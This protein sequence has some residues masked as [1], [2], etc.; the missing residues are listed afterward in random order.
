VLVDEVDLYL[1]PEW[2]VSVIPRLARAM[3]NLQFV[4][5]T[6]SPL[7]VGTLH[8]EN[9]RVLKSGPNGSVVEAS[10]EEVHGLSANQI[11]TSEY[12]GLQTTREPKFAVKLNEVAKKARDGDADSAEQFL[13]MLSLGADA[14][15]APPS[16]TPA[17][18]TTAART[19][20]AGRARRAKR[21]R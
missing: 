2:Q 21:M 9:I 14:G 20:A 5:T 8:R 4:F 16:T 3:P 6:H 17:P 12:F 18:A 15:E 10:Q 19:A 1:H 7:V 13:R 11:L